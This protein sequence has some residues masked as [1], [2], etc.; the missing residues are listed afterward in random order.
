MKISAA[1]SHAQAMKASAAKHSMM[2]SAL[3]GNGGNGHM[4]I[5]AG[6][7]T[8]AAGAV[9]QGQASQSPSERLERYA[10]HMEERLDLLEANGAE[11]GLNLTEV[12]SAFRDHISRLQDAMANG[13]QGDDLTTGIENTSNLVRDGVRSAIG[14]VAINDAEGAKGT[15]S[16]DGP[17]GAGGADATAS[18]TLDMENANERLD[19]IEKNIQERLDRMLEQS[20]ESAKEAVTG[21]RGQFENHME[22]LRDALASGNMTQ[23]DMRRSMDTIMQHLQDN[24][25][26]VTRYASNDDGGSDGSGGT[27]AT[28]GATQAEAKPQ[29]VPSATALAEAKF[30]S[31][32]EVMNLLIPNAK[33]EKTEGFESRLANLMKPGSAVG[34]FLL[35]MRDVT[36]KAKGGMPESYTP[37]AI[38]ASLISADLPGTSLNFKV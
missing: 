7:G 33:G 4:S 2:P 21:A 29:A 23:E 22:R 28:A 17:G 6:S 35:E 38:K 11:S 8:Q 32:Q 9:D 26:G 25:D 13:L 3:G 27:Q 20:P 16:M 10:A 5:Q 12:R 1:N 24:L 36:H 18:T 15:E 19:A 14:L 30:A 31:S 34:D 37:N